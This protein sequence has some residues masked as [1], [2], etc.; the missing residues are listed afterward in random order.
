MNICWHLKSNFRIHTALKPYV[1]YL[2]AD[3]QLY[4]RLCPSVGP[5]VRPTVGPSVGKHE[6]ESG[7]TSVLDTL[8]VC[9]SVDGG[10]TPL[11]TRPQRYCEPASLVSAETADENRL[12][13]RSRMSKNLKEIKNKRNQE[14]SNVAYINGLFDAVGRAGIFRIGV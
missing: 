2:V 9:L 12:V 13:I 11:P 4:E 1:V 6:S 14:I 7:K 8:Y 5:S 10:W 3:M